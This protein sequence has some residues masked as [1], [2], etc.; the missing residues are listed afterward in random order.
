MHAAHY[1]AK[2]GYRVLLAD[3]DPQASTTTYHHCDNQLTN[4]AAILSRAYLLAS[5]N[6]LRNAIIPTTLEN[7]YLIPG[8]IHL[9]DCDIA[10]SID[11]ANRDDHP[12][13]QNA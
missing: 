11:L 5:E 8:S 6:S 7:L 1:F 10:L 3:Y 2:L 4:N 9:H 12:Y 13:L